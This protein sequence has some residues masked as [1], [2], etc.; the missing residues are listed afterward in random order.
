[1]SVWAGGIPDG[2]ASAAPRS[3]LPPVV[4]LNPT[5]PWPSLP[6]HPTPPHLTALTP[7]RVHA[8]RNGKTLEEL[9]AVVA[10]APP[11]LASSFN[12]GAADF[13]P[14]TSGKVCVCVCVC[15]C[16]CVCVCVC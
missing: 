16:V 15:M 11:G 10:A 7:T 1:M 14:D 8:N 13:Y 12:L 2:A 9:Q 5:P 6:P 4:A 3:T